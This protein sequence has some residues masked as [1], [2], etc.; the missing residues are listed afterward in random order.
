MEARYYDDAAEFWAVARDLFE[1]EPAK[2]TTVLSV[3][4]AV[5]N[6]PQSDAEPLVLVTL[7]GE[8]GSLRGAALRT[9]PWPLALSGVGVDD[10][11]FLVGELVGRHPELDSV[12][13][14]SDVAN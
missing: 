3:V 4:H 6:A 5:L 8:S 9:P 14:P 12:M 1:A 11:P 7:H 2:H 13:G 10:M